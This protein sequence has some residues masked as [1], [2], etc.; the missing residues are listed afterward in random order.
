MRI[1]LDTNVLIAASISHGVCHQLLE[2][3]VV[4]HSVVVSDFILLEFR[5]KLLTKFGRSASVVD[6]LIE[7]LC[8][9]IEVVDP[10]V[11]VGAV[12]RDPD[13]DN[14]IG[15]ALAGRCS[16]I[17]TGDRDLLDIKRIGEIVILSPREFL[18]TQEVG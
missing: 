16:L 18:D 9:Q 1:V 15:T 8:S 17:I 11:V 14:V 7:T 5:Q 3:C 4:E 6:R 13:D 10:E 2:Y 12:E